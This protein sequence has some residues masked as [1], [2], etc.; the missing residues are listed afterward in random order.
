MAITKEKKEQIVSK[1]SQLVKKADLVVFLKFK[2]LTVAKASDLRRKL[3]AVG[4]SYTVAKKRLARL[5]LKNEGVEMPKLEG[6]VAF[7]VSSEEPIAAAKEVQAFAKA[8]KEEAV[9]L[10]GV[11]SAGGG[12]ASGGQRQLRLVDAATV[13]RLASI[14]P[15]E[16]LIAQ[17]LGVMQGPM[18]GFMGVL[19]GNQRKL[20]TALKQIADKKN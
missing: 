2:K 15:R 19:N 1:L 3:R 14:P 17:V 6:E 20:V 18:R 8:N 11:F 9:I 16:V 4:G 5:V 12:S 13:V 7:I 10:G